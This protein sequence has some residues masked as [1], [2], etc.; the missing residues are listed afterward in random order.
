MRI[1]KE[2]ISF[3]G[4][5]L[6]VAHLTAGTIT[7]QSQILKSE[8][9]D[10]NNDKQ[11]DI[12]LLTAQNGKEQLEIYLGGKGTATGKA[13]IVTAIQ[14][15]AGSSNLNTGTAGGKTYILVT[16]NRQRIFI[17]NPDD[18]FKISFVNQS[19]N[20]WTA[21]CFTGSLLTDGT[22]F[23]ILHGACLRRFT[24]P[25]KIQHG[26]FYGPQQNNNH[27][28]YFCDLNMDGEN[29]VVFAVK[30]QPL[31]RL[32]YAP[33]YG[34]MKFIPKE[35]S[36]FVELKTPLYISDI[37]IGDLNGDTRPDIAAT[38]LTEYGRA[39]RKTYLFFQNSPAGFT[40]GASPNLTIPGNGIPVIEKGALYLIDRKSGVLR[41][42]RNGKFD[43]PAATLKTGLT[44]IHT[45]K[46]KDGLFLISGIS[47]DRK[48]EVRWGN[49][50]KLWPEV[51]V[52]TAR[53]NTLSLSR[54]TWVPSTPH[55][56]KRFT[57]NSGFR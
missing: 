47:R 36:E 17:F 9:A 15:G 33:F 37:A 44:D 13:D 55:R 50:Q 16:G 41:I 18:Q 5:L 56:R 39:S 19:A 40:N 8:V 20:Q 27:S 29:D 52:N 45:F 38:T 49:V 54:T 32:Y 31:I 21:N 23:D 53:K 57:A 24:P 28:G 42:F 46:F 26:Y 11:P 30:G 4:L 12:I 7:P 1:C 22:S 10:V 48:S 51:P 34:K 25:D 3:L 2:T 35:L 6:C 14:D 43:K